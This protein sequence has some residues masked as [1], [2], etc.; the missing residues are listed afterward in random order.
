MR[1]LNAEGFAAAGRPRRTGCDGVLR[2]ATL[3]R[4]SI[5]AQPRLSGARK[6]GA[7]PMCA[8]ARRSRHTPLGARLSDAPARGETLA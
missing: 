1:G 2:A 7:G 3:E 8:G 6:A 4:T 5:S